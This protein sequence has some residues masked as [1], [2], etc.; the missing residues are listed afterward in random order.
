MIERHG[1]NL[2]FH[3]C[4]IEQLQKL[5]AELNKLQTEAEYNRA[6]A[7]LAAAQADKV[8]L[9]YVEQET[10][11]QHEREMD[12]QQAQARGNQALEVTKA[13]AKSR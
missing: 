9:D 1:W 13:L 12:K 5:Q 4:L 11:T 10:G 7:K 3:E 8:D 2:L 6:R